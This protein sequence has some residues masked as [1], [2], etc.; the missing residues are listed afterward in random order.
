MFFI[1]QL[2]Q[3]REVEELAQRIDLR[4][5]V[6][7]SSGKEGELVSFTGSAANEAIEKGSISAYVVASKS[8]EGMR[9]WIMRDVRERG[10]GLVLLEHSRCSASEWGLGELSELASVRDVYPFA[11]H[12]EGGIMRGVR[13]ATVGKGRVVVLSFDLATSEMHGI[14]A[15]FP[16]R[17]GMAPSSARALGGVDVACCLNRFVGQYAARAESRSSCLMW[18]EFRLNCV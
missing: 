3:L 18:M 4:H 8:T 16:R 5:D 9:S 13:G 11:N 6:V 1:R 15:V 2:A 17:R 7:Q 10:V 12:P 14:F